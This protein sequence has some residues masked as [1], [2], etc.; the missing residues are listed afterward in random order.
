MKLTGL[1]MSAVTALAKRVW[2]TNYPERYKWEKL[3]PDTQQ[4]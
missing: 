3:S 1:K 2:E 4:E